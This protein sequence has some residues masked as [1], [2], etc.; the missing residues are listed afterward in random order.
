MAFVNSAEWHSLNHIFAQNGIKT[1]TLIHEF[2]SNYSRKE[3]ESLLTNSSINVYSSKAT[4][5]DA[6]ACSESSPESHIIP[7][8]LID[9]SFGQMSRGV[10]K[11]HLRRSLG[12]PLSSFVVL[13]CGSTDQRKGLDLFIQVASMVL[14]E[15]RS[16]KDIHFIWIG[17]EKFHNY[18]L[19][20]WA[21][22]DVRKAK[23]EHLV[24]LIGNQS[25][26]EP[27]FAGSDVFVLPSR[28][29]PLPCVMHQAMAVGLP[30]IAFE[31]SGG[32][33]D[34]VLQGVGTLVPYLSANGLAQAILEYYRNPIALAAH[35]QAG[36]KLILSYQ[37]SMDR[38]VRELLLLAGLQKQLN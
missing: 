14:R 37:H 7:Q 11:E 13:A 16:A 22:H 38:Y 35:S 24:H 4:Q 9:P 20:W 29:D 25:D 19:F 26:I 10:G 27:Y 36:R 18:D 23:L 5:S 34:L 21:R 33:E 15:D 3:R 28:Q 17:G 6:K 30:I 2:L 31:G 8:G 1:V 12:I 32:A